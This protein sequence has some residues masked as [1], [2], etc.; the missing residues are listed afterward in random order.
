MAKTNR[1]R[2]IKREDSIAKD[3]NG[4]RVMMSGGSWSNPG[5][6]SSV[7]FLFEDKFTDKDK[8]S[9]AVS[10]LLKIE[11]QAFFKRRIPIFKFGFSKLKEDYIVVKD[12]YINSFD[13][14]RHPVITISKK[15]A[16]MCSTELRNFFCTNIYM[17]IKFVDNSN[18]F[19]VMRYEHFKSSYST[20]INL[21]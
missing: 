6:A 9:L 18:I 14:G 21:G 17:G 2:S 8:Y 20:I 7:E 12:F 5:D 15:S 1:E 11:K 13:E 10:K 19:V 3:F 16:T 4:R